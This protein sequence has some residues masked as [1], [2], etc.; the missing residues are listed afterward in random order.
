M[1]SATVSESE[2]ATI[3][4]SYN[5]VTERLKQSHEIL[6]REVRRL[7]D[8]L[9]E[10]RKEL[11]RRERLAALGE[12]AAGVAHEIRN[13]LGAI[14]LYAS[15]LE[16]DL[17]DKPEQRDI[18]QR[19]SVG[20]RNLESIVGDIL[21][22]AGES[23]PHRRGS[24]LGNIIESVLAQTAPQASAVKVKIDVDRRMNDVEVYCD[25]MQME[26]AVMNLVFNAI[27]A[28]DPGGSVWIRHRLGGDDHSLVRIL[29]EDDGPGIK[30][31]IAHRVFN[32]VFT[33]KDTG[34]GLGLA[35]VH[36]I[37]EAHGGHIRV[38]CR[39]G[40][41]ASLELSLPSR[42]KDVQVEQAGGDD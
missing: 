5:E 22:F 13:P 19:I 6:G 20:V 8:E 42:P 12:M 11:A 1:V 21:A 23:Q 31:E 24:R 39:A 40:G 3:V 29:V 32:P 15:L 35:I 41:G 30:P 28:C 18:A 37:V 38:G 17:E 14:G 4:E 10:K 25:P 34:T 16:K 9:L 26:R 33:T 36:R 27:D 7:R 2:L